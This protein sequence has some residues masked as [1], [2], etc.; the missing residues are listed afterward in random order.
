M[1]NNGLTAGQSPFRS[2]YGSKVP[3]F[4]VGLFDLVSS[5]PRKNKA[6]T[7]MTI[8]KR[9]RVKCDDNG[10]KVEGAWIR[11][12]GSV[13]MSR[14]ES[15]ESQSERFFSLLS[16]FLGIWS[17]QERFGRRQTLVQR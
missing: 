16:F 11:S 2:G 3:G 5:L 14:V 4:E 8:A 15:S 10:G 6:K 7:R 9:K 17:C 12:G 13:L 1:F